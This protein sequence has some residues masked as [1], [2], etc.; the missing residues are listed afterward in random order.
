M[1]F[2][3]G[4]SGNPYG[5]PKGSG[6]RALLFNSIV[7]EGK[8]KQLIIKAYNLALDGNEA[9]LKLMLERILPPKPIVKNTIK[10]E[11]MKDEE[12]VDRIRC[13]LSFVK[14]DSNDPEC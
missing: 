9:M 4:E 13:N 8:K 3:P 6:H 10:V 14:Q 1:K 12:M 11:G 7:D 5:R 2:Q